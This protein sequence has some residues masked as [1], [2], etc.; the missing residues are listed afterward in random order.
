MSMALSPVFGSSFTQEPLGENF[1]KSS[2]LTLEQRALLI[3][4]DLP[5]LKRCQSPDIRGRKSYVNITNKKED[6]ISN[7]SPQELQK[8]LLKINDALSKANDVLD[9]TK[10]AIN[11]QRKK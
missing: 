2:F 8:M 6:L 5:L 1:N 10:N 3:K 4:L 11:K 7:L 9:K